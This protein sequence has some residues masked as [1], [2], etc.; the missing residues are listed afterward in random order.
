MKYCPSC[1]KAGVERVKFCP[2]CGQS[3]T[4]LHL[5]E[6][7]R[8]I[9]EPEAPL[10]ESSTAKISQYQQTGGR[11]MSAK[12]IYVLLIMIVIAAIAWGLVSYNNLL[13]ARSESDLLRIQIGTLETNLEIA[14][15]TLAE[16]EEDLT[17]ARQGLV[18]VQQELSSV[19]QEL[20]SVER[21]VS[22]LESKLELY[23][24]TWGLVASGIRPPFYD[25]DIVDYGSATNPTWAQLLSFLLNDKTDQKA[26]V[27]DVYMCGGFARDVHNNAERAGIRAAYVD[28]ELP[29]GHHALNAF[30]TTDRGLVFIDCTGLEASQSGPSNCDKTVD[31]KIARSYIPKSLFPEIGWSVTWGNMGTIRDVEI[32]W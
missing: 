26:Y 1:G 8:P 13:K 14:E 21:T 2:Q 12:R 9:P 25:A 28:V 24:D 22:S 10:M 20:S 4:G 27:P 31:V 17:S 15:N 30:K 32:Y 19:Q 23:E 18:S 16:T 7:Q 29:G 11:V 6:K 3:L 5:E